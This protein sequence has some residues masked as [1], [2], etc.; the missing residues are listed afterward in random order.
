VR[1]TP[2]EVVGRLAG[3]VDEHGADE[4]MITSAIYDLDDRTRSYELIAAAA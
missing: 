1:G 3:L 4:L 2:E